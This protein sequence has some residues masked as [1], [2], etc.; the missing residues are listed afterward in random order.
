MEQEQQQQ[1]T[2]PLEKLTFHLLLKNY[3]RT[4]FPRCGFFLILWVLFSKA[5]LLRS[6]LILIGGE[7]YLLIPIIPSLKIMNDASFEL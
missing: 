3:H 6:R 4:K 5:D 2:T 1:G 7:E